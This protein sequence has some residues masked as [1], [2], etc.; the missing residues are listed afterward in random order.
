MNALLVVVVVLLAVLALVVGATGLLGLL[1][2][3]PGNGV[4]GV[5]TPETRRS[6]D[7]WAVANRAAG[8]AFLSA[9]VALGLGALGLGLIGGWVGAVVVV[10]ALV[11]VLAL[12]NVAGLAGSRSAAVWQSTQPDEDG[13]CSDGG[14]SDNECADSGCA[15]DGCGSDSPGD[16]SD[17]AADCGVTGGCGSC[18][19]QGMCETEPTGSR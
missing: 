14:C 7:A 2:R 18:A 17:P 6:P 11:A 12:L 19:L 8:P 16:A 4:L 13:C 5:R 10:A 15:D 3:L 1:G 9:G